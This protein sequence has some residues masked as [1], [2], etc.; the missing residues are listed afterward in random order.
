MA[1]VL[2]PI[3]GTS[4]RDILAEIARAPRRSL[5]TVL[6]LALA[7]KLKPTRH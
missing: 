4:H 2:S 3:P 6:R 5:L 7:G 1:Q